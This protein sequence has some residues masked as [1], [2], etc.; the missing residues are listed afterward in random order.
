[1]LESLVEVDGM[2]S[3]C[4]TALDGWCLNAEER[5]AVLSCGVGPDEPGGKVALETRM[6]HLVDVDRAAYS[7]VQRDT[8]VPSWL[9]LPQDAF[10]GLTPLEAIIAHESGLR[11]VRG[12]L[13][14]EMLERGFAW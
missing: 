1:M 10:G 8:L 3:R 12:M 9:R 5:R 2:N 6:R 13:R 4:T 11:F 7:L 14:Q